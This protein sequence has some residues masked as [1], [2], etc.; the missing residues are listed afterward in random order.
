MPQSISPHH[1]HV[2]DASPSDKTVTLLEI[3]GYKT[4]HGKPRVSTVS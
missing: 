1:V 2:R 3:S 4:T